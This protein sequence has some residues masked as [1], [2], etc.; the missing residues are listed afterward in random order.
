MTRFR[1]ASP[2]SLGF[3][4]GMFVAARCFARSVRRSGYRA[5][6]GSRELARTDAPDVARGLFAGAGR[7]RITLLAR[8]NVRAQS[9]E[10][11]TAGAAGLTIEDTL[12]P[13][14]FGQKSTQLIPLGEGRGKMR[15]R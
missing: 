7:C 4:L 8:V 6:H 5:D 1:S 14:A 15:L 2:K 13:Q 12:L 9:K 11:E 10:L 3:E